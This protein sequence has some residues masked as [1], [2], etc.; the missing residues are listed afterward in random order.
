MMALVSHRA[1]E[2]TLNPNML[3]MR[4]ELEQLVMGEM[5]L[6]VLKSWRRRIVGE[7]LLVLLRGE[8]ALWVDK[9]TLRVLPHK[10]SAAS[11]T[12]TED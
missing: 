12:L 4:K 1:A 3:A 6:P 2:V 9:G 10:P 8:L 11:N 7:D 5:E